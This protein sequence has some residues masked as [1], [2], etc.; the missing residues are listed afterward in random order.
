MAGTIGAAWR[1]VRDLLRGEIRRG[2]QSA[3]DLTRGFADIPADTARSLVHSDVEGHDHIKW[4]TGTTSVGEP[5]TF[6]AQDVWSKPL[7]DADGVRVGTTFERN[8]SSP[9]DIRWIEQQTRMADTEV[10]RV[11]DDYGLPE[12]APW[13]DAVRNSGQPPNYLVA[14]ANRDVFAA[15]VNRGTEAAPDWVDVTLNGREFGQMLEAHENSALAI[16]RNPAGEHV[17]IACTSG[18]PDASGA[19]LAAEHLHSSGTVTGNIHAPTDIALTPI[20]DGDSS[21]PTWL[22]VKSSPGGKLFET[23]RPPPGNGTA[24]LENS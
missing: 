10:L 15:S 4:L 7:T 16:G 12:D 24:P 6:R 22:G 1:A 14:H 20:S 17:F 13:A 3:A 11:V 8:T 9:N 5:I 23:Y 2:G 18:A 21:V 19:R